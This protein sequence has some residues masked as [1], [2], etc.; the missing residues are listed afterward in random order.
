MTIPKTTNMKKSLLLV[1]LFAGLSFLSPV[2]AQDISFQEAKKFA[3]DFTE[4]RT[5]SKFK[6]GKSTVIADS[7]MTLGWLFELEPRGFVI[8]SAYRSLPSV[9]AYSEESDFDPGDRYGK[10]L[11]Q[12]LI[13]D[14]RLRLHAWE[15]VDDYEKA[16][17]GSTW[18]AYGKSWGRRQKFQQ[19]PPA[20]TTSTGGWLETNW[21]QMSPYNTDCPMDLNAGN[22]S[23]AGCPAVAMAQVLHYLRL[24]ND[25]RFDSLD[26]YFH[27]YGA[28]NQYWIDDDSTARDF[29]GFHTLNRKLDSLDLFFGSKAEL[30][31]SLKAALVFACGTACRQVYTASGSGTFGI[32]QA[33]DAYQ[34]FG[35]TDSRL[36][37]DTD[38]NLNADLAENIKAG[39]CA[40]LGLVDS[41]ITVGHNVV[42][43]GYNTDGFYHF[44]FGWGGSYNGWYTMPPTTMPYSLT[45]IEGVVMDIRADSSTAGVGDT[46][47]VLLYRYYPNPVSGIVKIDLDKIYDS[48]D[49]CVFNS[50]GHNVFCSTFSN[51]DQI[52]INMEGWGVG[53][54]IFTM[55]TLPDRKVSFKV[56]RQ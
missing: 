15:R 31:N 8:I 30:T 5:K 36:V 39:L 23:V 7:S 53:V 32:N 24:T 9:Y 28:G 20:G 13:S 33:A 48:V 3:G 19:W 10:A 56:I 16:R 40:H 54:Y 18:L 46:P 52:K 50:V 51:T 22:R 45:V 26:D 11:L 29:P 6:A 35:F 44:N 25:T 34:R 43:D 41:A 47:P 14:M 38:T 27:S 49:L 42:V 12:L 17:V 55:R 4:V 21:T 2:L 1:I 37:F